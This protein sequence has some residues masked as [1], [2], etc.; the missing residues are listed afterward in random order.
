M[1]LVVGLAVPR[2]LHRKTT[3]RRRSPCSRWTTLAVIV[4]L[5]APGTQA[6]TAI[7]DSNI[8]TAATAWVTNPTTAA[9]TY[10]PI[11]DW[12]TATVST[13]YNL[14]NDA[15]TFNGDISEWNVASVA[16][17]SVGRQ[18][19]ESATFFHFPHMAVE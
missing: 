7:T 16:N 5:I 4:Q 14:F 15:A 12:D 11:A 13:M 1:T 9:T 18:F 3:S 6:F 19:S 10:G 2:R 17:M 8:K